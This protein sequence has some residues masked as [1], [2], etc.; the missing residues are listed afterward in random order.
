MGTI[1]YKTGD[2]ITLGFDVSGNVEEDYGIEEVEMMREYIE[3]KAEDI[4]HEWFKLDID[5]GYYEG[6]YLAVNKNYSTDKELKREVAEGI[7]KQEVAD[8]WRLTDEEKEEIK[9][10][11]EEL[12][13]E[14]KSLISESF[15]VCFPSWC[16]GYCGGIEENITEIDKAIDKVISEL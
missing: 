9:A 7:I 2:V 10:E 12:K 5:C 6:F 8:M 3:A 13:T 15:V 16:T 14:L 1:N 4:D 11:A